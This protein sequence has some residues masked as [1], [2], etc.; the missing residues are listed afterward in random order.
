[1]GHSVDTQALERLYAHYNRREFVHPDPL[2]FLYRYDDV[3]DREVAGVVASSLAY[4]RVGQIL[5]SVAKV[6][7]RMTGR[8]A[9]FL[10][11]ASATQLRRTFAGFTHRFT[12]GEDVARLLCGMKRVM[13]RHGSLEACFAA[14]MNDTDETVLP[15]LAAFVDALA[16]GANGRPGSLLPDPAKGSAC[17]R[18]HLFLRWMVRRD[19]VDPGGWELVA[20]SKLVVPLDT[21]MF[22][23]CRGFEF[24]RRRQAGA[25]AAL[26]VTA[27]FRE[28]APDDPVRYDFA[29]T[30]LGIRSD[31]DAHAL[32]GP[33]ATTKVMR[34]RTPA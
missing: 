29:L 8:P 31:A 24:T 21:H 22:R 4:G 26:E 9:E 20:P 3:R 15:A 6:L 10:E 12:S 30:R 32:L 5:K 2:E 7:D 34:R 28:L 23:L 16:N 17:K 1:M 14:G 33:R 11:R 25:R 13:K 19:A 27:R 18:L